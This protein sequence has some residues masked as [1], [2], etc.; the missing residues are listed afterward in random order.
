MGLGDD[1]MVTAFAKLEK[2]KF[3]D[4]Q[5]V[6][7]DFKKR[8]VKHSIV[9]ENNPNITNPTQIDES[10]PLH[11]IDY[12][13]FNRP[14]IDTIYSN[15]HKMVWNYNF[16]PTP[17]E[18]YF[19]QSENKKGM[20]ILENAKSHW[21]TNNK[22]SCKG[23]I[24]LE[25]SSSKKKDKQFALKHTN[26]DWSFENWS[27]LAEKLSSNYLVIQSI[28]SESKRIQN[29]Y[30]CDYD[31]RIACSVMNNSDIYVGPEGGFSHAAA[32]L[33][34]KAVIYF[35]GWID[36]KVTGY[37]FHQNVYVNIDGSPCGSMSYLCK[38]CEVCRKKISVDLV[39]DLIIKEL[40]KK[41]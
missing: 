28:H 24:F 25:S 3:P 9:Y 31:F 11:Y 4:R 38:H 23:I 35:G 15:Q 2:Q 30:Y 33:R 36:P 29:I 22:N 21:K 7:G 40:N 13:R 17:G 37:D 18:L 5:I 27:K 19:S 41:I 26:K 20:Q 39:Y 6:I 34:K 32:A 12:H 16:R 8:L 14:Y 1:I 10:K